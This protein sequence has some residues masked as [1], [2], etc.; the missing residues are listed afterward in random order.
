MSLKK[1]AIY[2][3]FSTILFS[4][5]EIVLKTVSS[6]FNPIQLTL[7]R[8]LIGGLVLLPFAIMT[9]RKRNLTLKL[10][11]IAYFSL[12]GFICVVVSMIFYQL[13]VINTKAS[14]VGVLFSCNP[15]FVMFLAYFILK[16]SITKYNIIS[17]ILEVVGILIIINPFNTKL[18]TLGIT[19]TLLAAIT[20]AIYGVLG[21]RKCLKFSSIVVTCFS[22]ILGSLEMLILVFFTH[23]NFISSFL[24]NNNL[25]IFAKVPL[26]S[27]Y[28][29]S[30]ILPMLYIFIGVTGLGYAFYF[31][32]MEETSA[33][34]ASLIFF[35][36]PILSPI[37]ALL[38]LR[39]AISINMATGVLFILIGSITSILPNMIKTKKEVTT[40]QINN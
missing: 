10:T 32:A 4:S 25:T 24:T 35:F 34:T 20:F 36:K 33:N 13:A 27:G 1:G 37:L 11:D 2:I 17:L 21:K 39:E 9:I 23:I 16:E 26:F 30:N 14:V 29:S 6:D 8:F 38:I 19:C 7:T 5:M 31:K 3:F 18:S 15:I 12:L 40:T 28:S 22:F